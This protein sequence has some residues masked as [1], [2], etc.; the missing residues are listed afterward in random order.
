MAVILTN[1]SVNVRFIFQRLDFFA[2]LS[3]IT[4]EKTVGYQLLMTKTISYFK[5]GTSRPKLA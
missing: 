3:L 4:D 5:G 1:T 2:G